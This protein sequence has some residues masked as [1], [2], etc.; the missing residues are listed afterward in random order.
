MKNAKL[1]SGLAA[2]LVLI[3]VQAWAGA[4][5]DQL[6]GNVDR[7]IKT[8]EDPAL[9]DKPQERRAAVRK[10]ANET[11]DFQET[12]KRALGQHWQ[13]RTPAEREEF[14][15]L[16][17]D[18]LESSYISKIDRY[19]GEKVRYT[20]DSTQDS[21]ATVRTQIVTKQGSEVPVDYRMHQRDGQWQ[22][23]DV[24][25][26]GVSLVAN[27]RTQFNKIIQTGSYQDLMQKLRAKSFTGRDSAPAASPSSR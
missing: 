17:S 22:V 9:K 23:Y 25:I 7:V 1:V 16:F 2:I 4:P 26:E 3:G 5:T 20:G 13:A 8:L 15:K 24:V 10:I 21:V 19:E 18:L 14:V 6:R 27:Y 12:A 11:F